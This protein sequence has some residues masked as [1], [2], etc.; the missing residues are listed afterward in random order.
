MPFGVKP[1]AGVWPAWAMLSMI[2]WR[3]IA[4]AIARRW[5]TSVIVLDV[6]PVVVGAER[7]RTAGS[8][9]AVFFSRASVGGRHA[10]VVDVDL[11][12]LVRL[13][14]GRALADDLAVDPRQ[15]DVLR[16]CASRSTSRGRAR[17]RAPRRASLNGPSV[18]MFFG[19]VHL[20]PYFVDR[21]FL[22]TARN[23]VCADLRDEPRLLAT[24]ASPSES[25]TCPAPRSRP[26]RASASQSAFFGSQRVVLGRALDAEEL[27]RVVG[28]QVRR[29]RPLPR[30]D[31]VV[32]GHGIAVRPLAVVTEVERDDLAVRRPSSPRGSASGF[33]SAPSFTSGSMMFRITFDEVVSVARPGSSDGG[34]APTDIV[35]TWLAAELAD[36]RVGLGRAAAA[37]VAAAAVV[38]AS[39]TAGDDE[40]KR[41]SRKGGGRQP[42]RLLQVAPSSTV[43]AR[44]AR[45]IPGL[46][47]GLLFV[48]IPKRQPAESGVRSCKAMSLAEPLT[49]GTR[50]RASQYEHRAPQCSSSR[51]CSVSSTPVSATWM[52]RALAMVAD[53]DDVDALAARRGRAA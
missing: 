31:E 32:R 47:F 37:R 33:R 26:C 29:D 49:P 21:R 17:R 36:V 42:H 6:E 23:D 40:R 15:L 39:A 4:I 30:P 7:R 53:R 51:V 34:S 13:L 2:A 50:P 45:A 9:R 22:F 19:S 24:S 48:R 28:R 5:F 11:A 12:G 10:G 25:C 27:V 14:G 46:P 16:R 44:P 18:T 43:R 3:S 41:R 20:L 1:V 8:R 35:T 38:A 52:P